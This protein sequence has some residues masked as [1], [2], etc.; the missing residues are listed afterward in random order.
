MNFGNKLLELLSDLKS[1]GVLIIELTGGEPL[2]HPDFNQIIERCLQL[3]PV[4][5]VDTNGY[6]L[7]KSHLKIINRYN[8]RV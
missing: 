5:G 7:K 4:V 8:N 3:F 2:S 1:L 6:L